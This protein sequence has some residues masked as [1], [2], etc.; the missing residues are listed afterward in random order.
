MKNQETEII[1]IL[2]EITQNESEKYKAF[3]QRLVEYC[4]ITERAVFGVL[5]ILRD[6]EQELSGYLSG[7]VHVDRTIIIKVLQ[8]VRIELKLVRDKLKCPHLPVQESAI[9]PQPLGEWT[10]DKLN[11]IELIYAISK[12]KSVNNGKIKLKEIQDC[13]EFVFQV[14]L[15]NISNRLNEIDSRKEN[16]SLYLELLLKNLNH[17]LDDKN[18]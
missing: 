6:M 10:D 13:F 8:S 14:K 4:T 3:K 9:P 5:R 16:D 11:L 1:K 2:Y 18:L 15:G 17:F 7:Q 12:T